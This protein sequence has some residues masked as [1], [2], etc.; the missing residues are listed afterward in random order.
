MT[1]KIWRVL[2]QN[3]GITNHKDYAADDFGKLIDKLNEV[4]DDL[5][6]VTQ[7]LLL[8]EVEE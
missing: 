6:K 2:T 7:V 5:A 3:K 1:I 4:R 8:S